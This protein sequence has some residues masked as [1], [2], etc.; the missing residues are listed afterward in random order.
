[1]DEPTIR[2]A[3]LAD[4]DELVELR[5]E[6]TFE[7]AEPETP[8]AGYEEECHA[9]LIDALQGG[10]WEIWVAEADGRI[11]SHA[12]VALV[13]KVPRPVD[14]ETR[15]AYL[16]NVYTRPAWRGRG[17]GTAVIAQAQAAAREAD[18]ELMIVWP[19]DKS[20]GFYERLGFAKPDEPLIWHAS[21]GP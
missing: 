13:D 18:V 5:S 14:E 20:V 16:T 4:I 15:I 19:S 11:V 21:A 7:D 9:F 17:I 8:R 3:R 6:F 12:F 2:P 10:R 1:V